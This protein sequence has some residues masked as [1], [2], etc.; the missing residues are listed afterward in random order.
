M[1]KRTLAVGLWCRTDQWELYY[2]CS[3]II[4]SSFYVRNPKKIESQDPVGGFLLKKN[5]NKIGNA[6]GP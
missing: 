2:N 3:Q 6:W 4:L 1:I 5:N